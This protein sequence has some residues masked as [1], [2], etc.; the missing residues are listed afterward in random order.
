MR[1][2]ILFIFFFVWVPLLYPSLPIFAETN[3]AQKAYSILEQNCL[4]CHGQSGAFR[5]KVVIDHSFLIKNGLVVPGDPDASVFYQRLVEKD[6]SKRMPLGQPQLST[7]ALTIVRDWISEGASD[8]Q[9]NFDLDRSFVPL[10]DLF[11]AMGQ[12]LLLLPASERRF[13]RYFTL[14]HLYNTGVDSDTL[15]TYAIALS[16]LVN[17]LSWGSRIVSPIP[18]DLERA[19]FYIDIRDYNWGTEKWLEVERLYPYKFDFNPHV[20]GQFGRHINLEANQ[21]AVGITG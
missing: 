15:T 12:H 13:A 9:S 1:K 2:A 16:K 17:S 21:L 8:W 19:I 20:C 18:I 6:M 11:E 4:N 14:T 10:S 5:E 3:L 7:M